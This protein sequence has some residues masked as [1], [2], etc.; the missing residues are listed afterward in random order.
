MGKAA[1]FA[2][3]AHS[4]S[5]PGPGGLRPAR[6]LPLLQA[7]GLEAG[8]QLQSL[9]TPAAMGAR[10]LWV[11]LRLAEVLLPPTGLTKIEVERI[12]VDG[13]CE[14]RHF[15]S[16]IAAGF[17]RALVNSSSELTGPFFKAEP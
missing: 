6:A 1:A 15:C 11:T 17:S 8:S 16:G 10:H 13:G 3:P 12:M 2:S 4:K 9:P 14:R 5:G 7:L